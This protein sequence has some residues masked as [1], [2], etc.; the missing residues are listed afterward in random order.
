[1][2]T[3][4]KYSTS[5]LKDGRWHNTIHDFP[6]NA[7]SIMN[8]FAPEILQQNITGY[9]SKSDIYSLGISCCEMAN[10]YIPFEGFQLTEMLLNKLTGKFPR[11]LDATC[12]EII[13]YPT[14][15]QGNCLFLPLLMF[16]TKQLF[17]FLD[18]KHDFP[19][20]MYHVYRH[21][22]YS[23]SFHKFVSNKTCLHFDSYLR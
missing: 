7:V 20:E 10:G 18:L 13:D 9:S 16:I 23:S 14:A 5:V 6:Q 1:M 15:P 21:K 11:P 12:N 2:L 22:N 17:K 8:Y 4:L 19:Q 3:G